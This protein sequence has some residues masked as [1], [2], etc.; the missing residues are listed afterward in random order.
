MNDYQFPA[1]P[2]TGK[3]W[4]RAYQ[5]LKSIVPQKSR[6]RSGDDLLITE[7]VGEFPSLLREA[8]LIAASELGP[9]IS[10]EAPLRKGDWDL[11]TV[12]AD[13]D[14]GSAWPDEI[15]FSDSAFEGPRGDW[16]GS[17]LDL[18]SRA[19]QRECRCDFAPGEAGIWLLMLAPVSGCGGDDG[20]WGYTGHLAGF[21]I[22]YDRDHDGVYESVG[23]I[24][25]AS[26]WR[27]RGI[28]AS[29]LREARS[30]FGY[31]HVE[32]PLTR[33]GAA[34]MASLEPVK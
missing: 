30:R 10:W 12:S 23:H 18:A 14:N 29:L 3:A 21:V 7:I 17:S 32:G 8:E 27:R 26:A 25:T 5:E 22:L 9:L 20:P 11:I 2:E 6:Y 24:W 34:L 4:R 31:E 1:E 33:A 19:Y 28:A 15:T 13:L 16:P